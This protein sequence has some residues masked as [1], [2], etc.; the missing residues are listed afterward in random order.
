[1]GPHLALDASS[2]GD[3]YFVKMK[4]KSIYN[5]QLREPRPSMPCCSWGF[6]VVSLPSN[7]FSKVSISAAKK[8]AWLKWMQRTLLRKGVYTSLKGA[9]NLIA[10]FHCKRVKTW[11]ASAFF[12]PL[13]E[14]Y[15]SKARKYFSAELS[16]W[17]LCVALQA[18]Q[19][20]SCCWSREDGCRQ[21]LLGLCPE[22]CSNPTGSFQAAGS[23]PA[24]LLMQQIHR[25]ME[26]VHACDIKI[27]LLH[28]CLCWNFNP[29]LKG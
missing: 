13:F 1:M 23:G 8:G 12:R 25:R 19:C 5:T 28:Y 22:H 17:G 15:N 2:T 14:L 16:L 21:W 6:K 10:K 11:L 9:I 3:S 26:F 4:L 29:S 20:F 24:W 18:G 7:L 27:V